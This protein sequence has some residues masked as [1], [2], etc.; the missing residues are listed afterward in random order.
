MVWVTRPL[1]EQRRP[2]TLAE[3]ADSGPPSPRTTL[4]GAGAPAWSQGGTSLWAAG[5]W[6]FLGRGGALP[7]G[8]PRPPHPCLSLLPP[9]SDPGDRA[10]R[11]GNLT[12][13]GPTRT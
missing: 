3:K 6:R 2:Q 8:L 9:P 10:V 13:S 11:T 5:P 4:A 7:A 1:P 12:P